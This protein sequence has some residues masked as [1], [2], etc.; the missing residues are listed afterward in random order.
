MNATENGTCNERWILFIPFLP[1][2]MNE[3]IELC[4]KDANA[5]FRLKKKYQGEIELIALANWKK[6]SSPINV[7]FTWHLRGQRRDLDNCLIA[8]KCILDALVKVRII[9]DDSIEYIPQISMKFLQS[10]RNAV[11]VEIW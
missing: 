10:R 3:V 8:A 4:K 2:T 9:E 1:P 6:H 7:R 11:S 5:Y